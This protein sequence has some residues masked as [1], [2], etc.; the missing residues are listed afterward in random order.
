MNRRN[1]LKGASAVPLVPLPWSRR[2]A[3][4]VP[5]RRARPSDQTWPD[6]ASWG[7]LN[8]KVEGRLIAV[9][10]PLTPCRTAPGSAACRDFLSQLENPYYIRDQ[11]G[12]TQTSG[13]A[14]AWT[15]MPSTY[16]I[17][18]RQTADVVAAVNFAR[19]NNLRLVVKGGGGGHSYQGTSAAPD[20]LLIW[21]RQM[22]AITLRDAFVGFG[23]G[24]AQTAQPAVTVGPGASPPPRKMR[25]R[26]AGPSRAPRADPPE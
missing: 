24:G 5:M 21:T 7:E 26:P 3:A 20:S 6:Q 1:L 10:S 11:A 23:C 18:V 19:D 9:Q 2:S 25:L 12:L 8:R 13:W 22:D 4:T 16:A 14:D 15:S 17:V